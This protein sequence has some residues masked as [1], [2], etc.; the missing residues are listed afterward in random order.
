LSYS[1]ANIRLIVTSL[2][3]VAGVSF[4]LQV[5]LHS[6]IL[7][8][9]PGA[10]GGPRTSI[11]KIDIVAKLV[12]DVKLRGAKEGEHFMQAL[13]VSNLTLSDFIL[14]CSTKFSRANKLSSSA[15]RLEIYYKP[16]GVNYSV[17]ITYVTY[18]RQRKNGC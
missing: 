11:N 14:D 8:V 17:M 5:P 3:G 9:S 6:D 10:C 12:F 16:S 15:D 18:C 4:E 1:C 2:M 13:D 7:R